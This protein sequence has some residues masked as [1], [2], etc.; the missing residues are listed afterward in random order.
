[1]L[2]SKLGW[3]LS[4]RTSEI[5]E[6]ST[7]SSMLIM[8]HGKGID[9]ETT[10]LT[11]LNKSLSMK[12]NLEHFWK[13]ES[14]GINYSPVESDND[15]ARKKFSETLKYDEGRYTVTWPWKQEQPD[16]PD[17][18]ALTL[19]RLKSLVSRKRNNPKLIQKY[20][21]IITDQREMGIIEKVGSES[22]SLIKHYIPHHAAINPTTAT[23][24]IRVVYDASAKCQK[25][26]VFMS[27]CTG[28]P[29]CYRT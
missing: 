16:L 27:V 26:E 25:A 19:G 4:G 14:I 21:D 12:T 24:E 6:N 28:G 3:I 1:M 13:L 8:T 17:N 18:R 23:T 9:D 2:G 7:E 5:V 29:S 20:N 22:N 10:F 15:V 11:C